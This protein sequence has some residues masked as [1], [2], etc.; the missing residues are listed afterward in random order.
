MPAANASHGVSLT[1]GDG[2]SLASKVENFRTA[3]AGVP[4]V[5]NLRTGH[6]VHFQG[7]T[8]LQKW[9]SLGYV[10]FAEVFRGFGEAT[11]RVREAGCTAAEGFDKYAITYERCWC[12]DQKKDQCDCAWLLVY[13]LRPKV[14]HCGTPCTK[15]CVLG[16]A[17]PNHALDEATLA[18][19]AFTLAIMKHQHAEGLGVSVENLKG[20]PAVQ[21]ARI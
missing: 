3:G 14:V 6:V 2:E 9:L 7:R 11:I 18:Q 1:C 4:S 20:Q 21:T 10:D 15:I 19:N 16:Q 8:E 12:L 5:G 13:S 17:F